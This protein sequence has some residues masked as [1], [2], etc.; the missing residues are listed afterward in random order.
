MELVP[1]VIL[2][3]GF[4]NIVAYTPSVLCTHLS[5]SFALSTSRHADIPSLP[6][7]SREAQANYVV[8]RTPTVLPS[9]SPYSSPVGGILCHKD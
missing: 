8:I 2:A 9:F 6:H 1:V 7:S 4:L 3:S 5:A